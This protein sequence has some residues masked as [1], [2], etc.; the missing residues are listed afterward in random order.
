MKAQVARTHCQKTHFKGPLILGLPA[1][2]S[3]VA[4][5]IKAFIHLK[6]QEVKRGVNEAGMRLLH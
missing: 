3:W 5:K 2:F 4:A 6:R 1:N